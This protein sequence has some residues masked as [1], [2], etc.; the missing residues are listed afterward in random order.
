TLVIGVLTIIYSVNQAGINDNENKKDQNHIH[1]LGEQQRDTILS[2]YVR[3]ISQ[4]YLDLDDDENANSKFQSKVAHTMTSATLRQLDPR[5][6]GYLIRYLRELDLLASIN[7]TGVDLTKIV[8]PRSDVSDIYNNYQSIDLSRSIL[9]NATLKQIDL[10]NSD[11][12]Y[13]VLNDA[14]FALSNCINVNFTYAQLQWTDFS[15]ADVTNATF[16]Y[17]NL[18]FSNIR[19]DQ[20]SKA[21]TLRGA[22][23]PDGTVHMK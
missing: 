3:D 6:R 5:R 23:L 20:L 15:G 12:A 1:I 19:Y 2:N 17:S 22:I 8:F 14:S 13:A 16:S 11:F 4:L 21:R 10:K 9:S 7:L 18:H